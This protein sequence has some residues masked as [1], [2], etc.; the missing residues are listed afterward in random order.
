MVTLAVARYLEPE[1]F[2]RLSYLLAMVSFLAPLMAMGM[3]SIVSRE[4]VLRP[5]SCQRI[6]GSALVIR[7]S[8][9]C[10]IFIVAAFLSRVYLPSH[11][12]SMFLLLAGASIMNCTL[13]FEFWL[14][15]NSANRYGAVL[16][17]SVLALSSGLRLIAVFFGARIE[18]FYYIASFEFVLSGLL[19]LWVYHQ[20]GEGPKKLRC[21]A[22]EIKYLLSKGRWLLF[23]GLAATLYMKIDQIM[24]GYL[25][26]ERTVG[27]YAV[28]AKLS[29]GWFFIPAAIVTAHFP[30][31]IKKR[32]ED[33]IAY[34]RQLQQLNDTLF[35]ISII[36][37]SAVTLVA[38]WFIETVFGDSYRDSSEVLVVHIW[39]VI[40]IFMR[41][42]LSKW[43][44][45]EDL[46]YLSVLSQVAGALVNV[47]VNFMLIPGFGAV[48]AAYATVIS[49]SVAS[50]FILFI[51]KDS[52]PMAF[53]VT[54]T[55]LL[56]FRLISSAAAKRSS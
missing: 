45:N 20:V 3:N 15:A 10:L 7:L 22:D 29:E 11:Q 32:D 25:I 26:D 49:Y 31:M 18:V 55:M 43:L 21:S 14:H 51:H 2:G 30:D 35:V 46:L 39:G 36:I 5:D 54:K 53:I 34:Q 38:P 48:G 6:L 28:A 27:I 4:L 47:A 24:L 41:S 12:Q 17:L 40:L 9:S 19:Y 50:Y 8:A 16:R 13:I 1:L 23:S 42:L 33:R 37:A 52:R 56:P 44:I